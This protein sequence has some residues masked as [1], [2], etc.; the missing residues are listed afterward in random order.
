MRGT[1]LEYLHCTWIVEILTRSRNFVDVLKRRNLAE[2]KWKEE[3]TR[4]IWEG[5]KIIYS[6]Q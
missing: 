5:Y 6:D 3:K 2:V 1:R 4:E